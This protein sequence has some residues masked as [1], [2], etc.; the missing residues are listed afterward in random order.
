M[1]QPARFTRDVAVEKA[2]EAYRILLDGKPLRT[3]GGAAFLLP[4][5]VLALAVADEWQAQGKK[6]QPESMPLTKLANTAIDRVSADRT[7]WIEQILAFAKSDSV[8]YRATSP[9]DL[10]ARQSAHWD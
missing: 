4:N 10:V 1:R 6:I 9:Q 7:A 5:E 8:C 3:P 2:G